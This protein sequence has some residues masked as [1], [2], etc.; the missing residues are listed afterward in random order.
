MFYVDGT[1]IATVAGCV[2]ADTALYMAYQ[3][4]AEDGGGGGAEILEVD[5]IDAQWD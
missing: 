3:I 1:L 2:N 4:E 5:H